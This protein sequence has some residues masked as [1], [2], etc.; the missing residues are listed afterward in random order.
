MSVKVEV[1]VIPRSPRDALD[2]WRDGRLVV[3]VTAPPVD[4]AA[5]DAVVALLARVLDVPKSALTITRGATS[6]NK[7]IGVADLDTAALQAKLSAILQG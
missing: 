1:R 4:R 6:R 7:T 5:N 2:G 3:R